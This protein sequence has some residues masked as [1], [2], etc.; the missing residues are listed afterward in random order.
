MAEGYLGKGNTLKCLL[1]I[2]QEQD[3]YRAELLMDM[4]EKDKH[5]IRHAVW[6]L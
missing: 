2:S 3:A 1:Y 5:K 6:S 4:R